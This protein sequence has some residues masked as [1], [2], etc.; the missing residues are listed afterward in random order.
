MGIDDE[1]ILWMISGGYILLSLCIFIGFII[2]G[3]YEDILTKLHPPKYKKKF[4]Y[5]YS[6]PFYWIMTIGTLPFVNVLMCLFLLYIHIKP[7]K[8]IL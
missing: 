1:M 5:N 3:A 4:K 6:C 8:T 2:A 7:K